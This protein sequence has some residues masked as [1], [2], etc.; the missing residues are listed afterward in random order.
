MSTEYKASRVSHDGAT[1]WRQ[2]SANGKELIIEGATAAVLDAFTGTID[3]DRF[4]APANADNAFALRNT[5]PWLKPRLWRLAT[6]A[7]T[8]DRLG[9]CTPGHVRAF[10]ASRASTP[11]SPSSRPGRWAE[12]T[13]LHATS[14]TTR[15]GVPSRA[16][17]PEE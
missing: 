6:S 10:Q 2:K 9:L 12:L 14:W 17:G 5:L 8:G 16:A 1:F 13:G 15:P 11:S 7:G 3:G 4:T